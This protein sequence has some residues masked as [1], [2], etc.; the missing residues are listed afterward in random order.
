MFT[1]SRLQI[2]RLQALFRRYCLGLPPRGPAPSVV[3][4]ADP[5]GSLHARIDTKSLVLD[6]VV[7]PASGAF[8]PCPVPLDALGVIQGR[9]E[10]PVSIEPIGGGRI[11]ARWHDRGIPQSRD[12]EASFEPSDSIPELPGTWQI[13]RGTFWDTLT[14]ASLTTSDDTTRFALDCIQLR[15]SRGEIIATDGRQLLI[16]RGWPQPW[17][18]ELLIPSS[19]IFAS[20]EWSHDRPISLG[21]TASHVV[22]KSGPGTLFL[23]IRTEARY[24]DISR[25]LAGDGPSSTELRLDPADALFLRTSLDRLPSSDRSDSPVTL[26]LNGRIAVRAQ[27]DDADE[28]TELVLARSAYSGPAIRLAMNR[29]YLARAASLGLTRVLATRPDAPIL[30]TD[31]GRTYAWQPLSADVAIGPAENTVR[32]E[33]STCSLPV[34]HSTPVSIPMPDRPTQPPAIAGDE[35]PSTNS[36]VAL[37][38]DA[39]SIHTAV[40]D[41]KLRSARLTAA[42]RRYRKRSRLMEST[43][44]TLRQLK[45]QDVS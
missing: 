17:D 24:P 10:T 41:L 39:E 32:V 30:A 2:R 36:L 12:W 33:S 21:R 23:P 40:C 43:L 44:S 28:S 45:L 26:D 9:E 42:L 20:P 18:D 31:L 35:P 13:M 7:G 38:R 6:W 22:L 8:D 34:N 14:E 19:P 29:Q 5:D 16:G 25:I 1:T 15:G 27:K 11:R 4:V 3:F 37:I